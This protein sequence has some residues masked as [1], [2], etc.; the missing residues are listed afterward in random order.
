MHPDTFEQVNLDPAILGHQRSLLKEG[1]D[2]TVGL[3]DGEPISG[4]L[5]EFTA[6]ECLL[7][8]AFLLTVASFGQD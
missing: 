8:C 6:C 7:I 5:P 4:A 2:V 1:M 3:L